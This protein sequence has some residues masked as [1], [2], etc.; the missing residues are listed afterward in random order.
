MIESVWYLFEDSIP[1]NCPSCAKRNDSW[2]LTLR[3]YSPWSIVTISTWICQR[4]SPLNE[5]E[6]LF[7]AYSTLFFSFII[8]KYLNF[9]I[10]T[11]S[12]QGLICCLYCWLRTN[13]QTIKVFILWW[14]VL[15]LSKFYRW[16]QVVFSVNKRLDMLGTNCGIGQSIKYSECSDIIQETIKYI[17][18]TAS[19]LFFKQLR[20][21]VF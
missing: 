1:R 7:K 11:L 5:R 14:L 2:R 6:C 9:S 3:S 17:T 12:F 10:L 21:Y 8:P 16:Q 18:N 20:I 4:E 19:P 15:L 13:I